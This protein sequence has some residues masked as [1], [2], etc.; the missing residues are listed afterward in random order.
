MGR[1]GAGRAALDWIVT[2]VVALVIAVL[3]RTFVFEVYIVPS[4]SMLETIQEGDRLVGEKVSYRL[5]E[6]RA[7]DVVTFNDPQDPSVTLIKRVVAVGGQ[8]VDMHDGVLYIDGVP[9]QESYTEG[10]PTEP[11]PTNVVDGG[12]SYPYTVPEGYLWVMGDNRTNSLDSRYFGP[13]S[14]SDVT[15]HAAFIFWPLSD[16][17]GL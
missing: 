10:K 9:Q 8:T 16:A 13:I 17:G 11:L 1:K 7:G 6:P 3:L 14:A 4:G 5:T 15:S 2:T 12:L